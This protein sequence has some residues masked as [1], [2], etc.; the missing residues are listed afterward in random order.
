MWLRRVTHLEE[1][2]PRF[3][4]GV[5][6]DGVGLGPPVEEVEGDVSLSYPCRICCGPSAPSLLGVICSC[7]DMRRVNIL[8]K[9]NIAYVRQT[10]DHGMI[11]SHSH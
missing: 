8:L 1:L 3:S 6:H 10:G 5:A 7:F 9:G 4:N 2:S 11:H